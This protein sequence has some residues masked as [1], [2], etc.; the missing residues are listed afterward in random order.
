MKLIPLFLIQK[1][2]PTMIVLERVTEWGVWARDSLDFNEDLMP[3]ILVIY[4]LHF[5]EEDISLVVDEN[6]LISVK[7]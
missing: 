3:L 2:K 5:L 1:K 4:F 7:I 6:E